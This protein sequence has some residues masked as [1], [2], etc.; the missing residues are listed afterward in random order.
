V[1]VSHGTLARAPDSPRRLCGALFV[2]VSHWRCASWWSYAA[3]TKV[4][5]NAFALCISAHASP[6]RAHV[7]LG[8][9]LG[10][11]RGASLGP[12]SADNEDRSD[13]CIGDLANILLVPGMCKFRYITQLNVDAAD[14]NSL[15]LARTSLK[16]Q[17]FHHLIRRKVMTLSNE[18]QPP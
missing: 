13:L 9:E 8:N 4:G 2:L 14:N 17:W 15:C 16:L 11:E 5:R 7:G 10:R 12:I 3:M 18:S 6:L 1:P